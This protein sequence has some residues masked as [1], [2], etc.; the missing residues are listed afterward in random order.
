MN[1]KINLEVKKILK[2]R[3]ESAE[4]FASYNLSYARKNEEFY[5]LEKQLNKLKIDI[6]SKEISGKDAKEEKEKLIQLNKKIEKVLEKI[7]LTPDMLTAS[8][9]C[10]QCKDTGVVDGKTC[11][12]V[13]KII[14]QLLK[15]KSGITE[16]FP[17]FLDVKDLEENEKV[18]Y[19]KMQEWCTKFPDVKNKNIFITG[20]VGV[21][22]TF[23]CSCM[24]NELIK[25][26]QFVYY[27]T[28][29]NLN[30]TFIDYCKGDVSA[31]EPALACDV[32]IIDDLGTEPILKNITLEY[33]YLVL[34]ERLISGKSTIINSNLFPDAIIDK[35]GERI[36]SRI[37][38]KKAGIVL[39]YQGKD[40][41]LK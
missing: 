24:A 39:F 3:K 4:N 26:G 35:Y 41:R 1:E 30:Q 23:L 32:L 13:N 15:E 33:L 12:C 37:M 25:K 29:F 36:F 16:E 21:G 34:N 40:K 5:N 22:K 6:A 2:Q 20:D 31:L 9:T 19:K 17:S 28:A 11:T 27:T 14:S 38:N 8:Y 7:H 10:K 18:L